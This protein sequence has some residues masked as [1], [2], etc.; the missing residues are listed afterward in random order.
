V[1]VADRDET[2]RAE[3]SAPAAGADSTRLTVARRTH[4]TLLV[5]GAF[6]A[7]GDS[8]QVDVRLVDGANGGVIRALRPVRVPRADPTRGLETLRDRVLGGVALLTDST[9]GP[10]MLPSGDPPTYAAY[11]G[12]RE[13]LEIQAALRPPDAGEA[14]GGS[15]ARRFARA[16]EADTT[17]LQAWLW[18]ASALL[19][20]PG[21]EAG[22]DSILTA[23]AERAERLSPF[24]AA[25]TDALRADVSGNHELSARGWRRAAAL[26]GAWPPRWW[27]ASKLR[28]ANRPREAIVVYDSLGAWRPHFYRAVP[29]IRH[30]LGDYRAE[31]AVLAAE[32]ARTPSAAQTLDYQQAALQALAA[33]DSVGAVLRAVDAVTSL[34]SE[35]GTS[36]AY[37]LTRSA[38]ELGSHGHRDAARVLF[39]RA[40]AWCGRRAPRELRNRLLR[41][42]CLEVYAGAA[43]W[44]EARRSLEAALRSDPANLTLLGL[45]GVAAAAAGDRGMADSVAVVVE[46]RARDDGSRGLP[47]WIRAR[48]AGTLGDRDA[49]VALL[50]DAFARGATWGARLDLHRDPAFDGLRGYPPF[51]QLMRPQ[52]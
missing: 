47:E 33:L 9:F 29:S 36:V 23:V 24:E 17:Y 37:L 30:Y 21:G 5:S 15:D 25:M 4:A 31:W 35:G 51:E 48:I 46:A 32:S 2:V 41:D 11:L 43:P 1:A 13:G 26:A 28:D 50:R 3:R 10:G 6:Y 49:T 38:W 52:G 27:L 14:E 7:I 12:V 45:L 20:R 40:V 16:A 19:R 34:P 8:L 44:G 22:A 18:L 42:D 39:D